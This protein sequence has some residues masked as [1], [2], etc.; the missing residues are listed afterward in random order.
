MI[1]HQTD[2]YIKACMK[3]WLLC[4]SCIYSETNSNSP[5]EELITRCRDCAN[6]CFTV[7]CR[8][9]NNSEIVQ[10]SAFIC[11]LYCRECQAACDKYGHI[12]DI[13]YC[14]QICKLCADT[15][16]NLI[17]PIHLN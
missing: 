11:M 13:Y 17:V 2:N 15:L 4:E 7:V 10:E 16:K 5:R 9:L 6:A 1:L 14:G 8:I 3:T 12:E